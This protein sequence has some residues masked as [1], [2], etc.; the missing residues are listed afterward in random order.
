[1]LPPEPTA[2]QPHPPSMT[3]Q[4]AA[5]A[6]LG[7]D[8]DSLGGAV[9]RYWSLGEEML[10]MIRRQPP[11]A[12]LRAALGDTDTLRLTCS[13]ANELVDALGLPAAKHKAAVEL[14]VRRY[15][16]TLNL[17]LRDIQL[18]IHP[19]A[20]DAD[21]RGN[22]QFHAPADPVRPQ[23]LK[24][25]K[26][27]SLRTRLA[28]QESAQVVPSVKAAQTTDQQPVRS[29]HAVPA[30]EGRPVGPPGYRSR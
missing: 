3:E 6:V 16:R 24:E 2:D 26:L 28:A 27:S 15:A 29:G 5:F 13:L 10:Q 17:T 12:A 8:L 11:Q 19:E 30:T 4:A 21:A 25:P 22:S 20:A 18:A 14:V 1:M 9:A 7:C 23:A